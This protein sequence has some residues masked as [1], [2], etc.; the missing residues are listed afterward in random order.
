ML[1]TFSSKVLDAMNIPSM[2]IYI[3]VLNGKLC[4]G[5][6][7]KPFV[8]QFVFVVNNS[9]RAIVH[10]FEKFQL[11]SLTKTSK[12]LRSSSADFLWKNQRVSW[13]FGHLRYSCPFASTIRLQLPFC[14]TQ[15]T[16]TCS[17]S[18]NETLGQGVKYVQS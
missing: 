18:T 12:L 8:G 4:D 5:C 9:C 17:K 13:C 16:F 11:V 7:G 14:I 3:Y 15:L 2:Y 10:P 6:D 1:S